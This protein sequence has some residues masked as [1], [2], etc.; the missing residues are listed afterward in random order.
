MMLSRMPWQKS[1]SPNNSKI[2]SQTDGLK[3]IGSVNVP[4][5]SVFRYQPIPSD[6]SSLIHALEECVNQH[7]EYGFDQ[8]FPILGRMGFPCNHKLV[9]PVYRLLGLHWRSPVKKRLPCP[10]AKVFEISSS[11]NIRWS[12]DLM[13]D[14]CTSGQRFGTLNPN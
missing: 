12:I 10:Q 13:T 14:S 3:Y 4:P 5:A 1:S 2:S 6:D 8:L 9:R 11:A 7:L